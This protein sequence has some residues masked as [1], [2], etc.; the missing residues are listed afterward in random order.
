MK[1]KNIIKS[2]IFTTLC[3]LITFSS[4]KA[5]FAEHYELA[6]Q[7]LSQYQY[8]SAIS[9]FKK[10][11]RINYLDDSARIGLVN[12]Y[13]A[14]GTYFA[15][16]D[17]DWENAAN[18]YRA[19]L[20]YLKYYP[21]AQSVQNS[22]QAIA[23]STDNLTQC[24]TMQKF[25]AS[26]K[27]R[28]EK[29]KQLR[30]QGLFPE[31]GYE[32]AQTVS[33]PALKKSAYE[34]IGDILKTLG[35]DPKCSEYYQKAV[36]LNQNDA[37]IRLKYARVLDKLGQN[38]EAA[39]E[40]NYA[41]SLGG[42]DPE[43]LYSIERIY[44]QKLASLPNDAPTIM[45]LGAI[46]QKQNKFD[47][48]LQYYNQASQLDPTNVTT[49]LNVGTL[50]Q[51]KKSY[52]AAIAAYDSILTLYPDNI[53]A[54]LYKSQ[55]LAESGQTDLATEGFKRV[56]ALDPNNKEAKSEIFDIKKSSMTPAEFASYLSQ[57]AAADKNSIND[58]YDYA[59]ELHKQNKLD[60]AI[61]CYKEVLKIKTDSPEVYINLAIAYKQKNDV[62]S[63]KQILQG[64]KIKFPEN[65]QIAENLKAYEEEAIAGK[66]DEASNYYNSGDY[67][68]ALAIY[69]AV[70]PPTFDSL[71]GIAASY[72]G[73]N[74]DN[75]AI[76]YYKKALEIKPDS[77]IAYY[78]GVLFSEKENWAN[79]K[80]YLKKSL[81]LNPNN[82]KAK[83]LLGTVVE[84]AN[85]KL[86]D[87]A[88]ALYDK[89]DYV[90]ALAIFNKVLVEDPKNAYCY[91]YRGLINDVNKKYLLAIA[92]YKKAIQY[93]NELCIV[94][95]LM[96]LDYDNLMQYKTAL[97]NYKKYVSLTP[98]SNEYK[99]YSQSRIKELKKYEQ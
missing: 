43:L 45:N 80:I 27:S 53:Q 86:V 28:F 1:K 98:E 94:Y 77:D 65:K 49:R 35:N 56:L 3:L 2:L 8:S 87:D 72:K 6:Q 48:A 95:Y 23:N 89:S 97:I 68:K 4:A 20:F 74:N 78:I 30:L 47:E 59:I 66:F 69:Q 90:K 26:A 84:Q 9:E 91:Y 33:D 81:S 67:Q 17:R 40:Y 37:V 14:R 12:A 63:A 92:D 11:L 36:A 75:Q 54:N 15:N 61:A 10:A 50:Y 93:S 31:A 55:C 57:N 7:Y 21:D 64:A 42:D 22:T 19:A 34:Q 76:E 29:A 38:D 58:L 5:D 39:K 25:D 83:D 62:S 16:K 73:L 60:D 46:L 13:L 18:D 88:I 99:T 85:I 41:L 82:A 70:Q 79:S 96:A 71:S 52:D 44:R 51:Q 24:L 32:F